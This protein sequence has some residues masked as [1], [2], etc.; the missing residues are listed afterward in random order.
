MPSVDS[1]VQTTIDYER[2]GK[3]FG[4]LHIPRSTNDSAWANLLIP[5]VCLRN[6][7][8]PTALILAGCHGDEPEGQIAALK[9]ARETPLDAVW[10]RIIILPCLS[11]EA[12]RAATRL[13]PGGANLNRSFPGSPTGAPPDV[14]ADYLTRV[15]FPMATLVCDF[16]SGGRSMRM[17]PW[18]EIHLVPD[19]DQRNRMIDALLA[20]NTDYHFVYIDVAGSGLLVSEAE[21]QGKTTIG[22]ELGGGGF[23][24]VAV[25]RLADAGLRNMLRQCGVLAG[26]PRTRADLGLPPPTILKALDPRDYL[27][28]PESGLFEPAVELGDQVAAGATIGW[29]HALEQPARAAVEITAPLAGV[30]CALRAIAATRQGD[31]VAVLGQPC[32]VKELRRGEV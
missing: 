24:T 8:G 20:W 21:R 11:P 32:A 25:Q 19:A 2:D 14:L 22:T 4:W 31:G 26:A 7:S 13:W 27:W 10:G 3:Q 17:L 23:T 29:L 5:V 12:A 6:G 9:L 18:S 30:V 1:P 28:A 15:L 16:H